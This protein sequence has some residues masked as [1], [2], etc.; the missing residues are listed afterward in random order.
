MFRSASP[1]RFGAMRRHS[2]Q[3]ALLSG[4]KGGRSDGQASPALAMLRDPAASTTPFQTPL[5]TLNTPGAQSVPSAASTTTPPSPGRGPAEEARASPLSSDDGPRQ[6]NWDL[7]NQKL[8]DMGY[9]EE[10]R[11]AVVC[12]GVDLENEQAVFQFITVLHDTQHFI[13]TVCFFSPPLLA[14]SA[15]VGRECVVVRHHG[16]WP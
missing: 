11:A 12:S 2:A 10:D 5:S 3:E 8:I 16:R 6:S 9:S 7:I 4:A 15:S 13:D 14:G 1:L